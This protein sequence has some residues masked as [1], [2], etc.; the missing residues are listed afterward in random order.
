[1]QLAFSE[2]ISTIAKI[3]HLISGS[4]GF[5]CIRFANNNWFDNRFFGSKYDVSLRGLLNSNGYLSLKE[6]KLVYK[7]ET[8]NVS[9]VA[10]L[11][12]GRLAY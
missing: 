12:F 8:A 7:L 4:Q 9:K 11:E 3:M 6:L 10:F 2:N 1:M 5:T